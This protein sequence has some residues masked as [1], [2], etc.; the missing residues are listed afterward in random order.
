MAGQWFYCDECGDVIFISKVELPPDGV[1]LCPWNGADAEMIPIDE[2]VARALQSAAHASVEDDGT[3]LRVGSRAFG[4]DV[5]HRGRKRWFWKAYE[6]G[7]WS[8]TIYGT[9]MVE[10]VRRVSGRGA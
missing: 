8:Y 4:R 3:L 10:L 6:N 1:P 2:A 5:D 9:T 7:R